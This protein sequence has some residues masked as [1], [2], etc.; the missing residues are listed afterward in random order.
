MARLSRSLY[1]PLAACRVISINLCC[2]IALLPAKDLSAPSVSPWSH[3]EEEPPRGQVPLRNRRSW[4][5]SPP[6]LPQ[7]SQ[8]LCCFY[9]LCSFTCPPRARFFTLAA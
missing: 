5:R 9:S 1:R 2:S 8:C 3:L 4:V 6:P 7:N